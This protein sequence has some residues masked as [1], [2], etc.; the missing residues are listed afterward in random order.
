[1]FIGAV[2]DEF[3]VLG[4]LVQAARDIA[5]VD[6]NLGLVGGDGL[7]QRVDALVSLFQCIDGSVG[8]L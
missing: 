8:R 3:E 7:H 1:M 5:Q 6:N 4:Q 2:D